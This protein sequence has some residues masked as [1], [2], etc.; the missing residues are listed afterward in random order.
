MDK[1]IDKHVASEVSKQL[2]DA[3]LSVEN[4]TRIIQERC[5]KDEFEGFRS[6]AG[7]V[8]G[9]LYL[10]LEPLWRAYPDLA[11]EGLDMSASKKKKKP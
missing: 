10:L 9:G 7:K 1:E 3:Y 8:A 11:P 6:E 5:S 2:M 4:A